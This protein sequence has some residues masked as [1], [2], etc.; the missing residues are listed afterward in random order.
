MI[1]RL[2][3][4]ARPTHIYNKYVLHELI[5]SDGEAKKFMVHSMRDKI[6]YSI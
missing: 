3:K 4:D 6:S 5:K 2:M 1:C